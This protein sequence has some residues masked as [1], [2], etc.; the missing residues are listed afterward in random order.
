MR[1]SA[2]P[3]WPLDRWWGAGCR[4]RGPGH[5]P[6]PG[7]AATRPHTAGWS[8]TTERRGKYLERNSTV[9]KGRLNGNPEKKCRKFRYA[10]LDRTSTWKITVLGRLG[11]WIQFFLNIVFSRMDE[12]LNLITKHIFF[13]WV[14]T[15][16]D[17]NYVQFFKFFITL[18]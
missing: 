16:T 13:F 6:H 3:A 8:Y 17:N 14:G 1:S 9:L 2:R 11:R 5:P 18:V 7:G 4:P 12:D 10:D 15:D